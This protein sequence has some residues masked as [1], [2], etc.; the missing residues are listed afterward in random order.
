MNRFVEIALV[1]PVLLPAA[2]L[3]VAAALAI[4]LS[5]PGP[6]FYAHE[7]VGYKR[8]PLKILKLRTMRVG[9]DRGAQ[10][11]AKND[12]RITA[13]GRVLRSTKIDELPQLLLVLRGEMSLVGPRPEA[14]RYV[15]SYDPAWERVFDVRPGITDLASIAFR[16]EEALLALATDK[17]RA[18]LEAV[19][20]AKMDLVLEGVDESSTLA[21][22]GVIL[23]TLRAV[24]TPKRMSEHPA[25]TRARQAI[26]R[27]NAQT[28]G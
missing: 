18:Y 10:V 8:R 16:N 12:A 27:L 28:A 5:S 15:V 22:L 7:R 24:V 6:A 17:E 25:V 1:V 3:V 19:L 9:S 20:P 26:L 11:T 23:R 13:I 4:K 21:D 2:S 14:E